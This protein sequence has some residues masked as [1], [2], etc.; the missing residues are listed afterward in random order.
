M[1]FDHSDIY[2]LWSF[3]PSNHTISFSLPIPL[4]GIHF[5]FFFL[6][7]KYS[8]IF[9]FYTTKFFIDNS[10]TFLFLYLYIPALVNCYYSYSCAVHPSSSIFLLNESVHFLLYPCLIDQSIIHIPIQWIR[11]LSKLLLLNGIISSCITAQYIHP[12]THPITQWI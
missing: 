3:H 12:F 9:C 4:L 5:F 11:F 8:K 1:T 6:H 7:T 10:S 2:D